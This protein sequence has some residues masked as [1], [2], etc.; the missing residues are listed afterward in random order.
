LLW[1]NYPLLKITDCTQRSV[2]Q[3][4][5]VENE[6][7]ETNGNK[8]NNTVVVLL[9]VVAVVLIAIVVLLVLV[10]DREDSAETAPTTTPVVVTATSDGSAIVRPQPTLEPAPT[11]IIPTPEPQDPT[12]TVIAPD[13]VNLRSGPGTNYPVVGTAPV[14]ATSELAGV[15]QDGAWYA[16][17]LSAAPDHVGWVDGR[18]IRVTNGDNLRV[19]PNPATPTPT[20]TPTP[21]PTPTPAITFTSTSYNINS[22]QCATLSWTT[23]NVQGVWVYPMGQNYLN[24]G[25]VGTG[26]E[27]VCPTMTTTYEMRIQMQ[28]GSIQ[29]RQLTI[30]VNQTNP[31]ANTFWRVVELIGNPPAAGSSMT[32]SFAAD[33]TLSAF[34][35]CN[36]YSA[37]YTITGNV[38]SISPL[39]GSKV[40]CSDA[41]DAQEAA[42]TS[43]LQSANTFEIIS[44]QLI[45]RDPAG[46]EVLRYNRS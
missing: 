18:F 23:S 25:V 7:K 2:N 46:R 1:D 21:V 35:G 10:L 26:T 20:P 17:V 43:A 32:T 29:T 30:T 6:N 36:D 38:I 5:K 40:S 9:G 11:L 45:I 31:L 22:G 13:G 42:F 44:G 37:T 12:G 28:D 24:N 15:S 16:A 34:G 27:E 19:L 33:N 3:E 41:I 14:G 8:S 39:T 4:Q